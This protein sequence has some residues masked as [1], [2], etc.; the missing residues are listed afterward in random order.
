LEN[1]G[2]ISAGNLKSKIEE[3]SKATGLA[4]GGVKLI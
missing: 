3:I 4:Q 2:K 1:F